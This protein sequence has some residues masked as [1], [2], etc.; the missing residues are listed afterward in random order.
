MRRGMNGEPTFCIVEVIR[1]PEWIQFQKVMN[2]PIVAIF[3]V[4]TVKI[5]SYPMDPGLAEIPARG[6]SWIALYP[7]PNGILAIAKCHGL[8]A[9]T[10]KIFR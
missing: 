9:R 1:L 2:F 8:Q 3:T 10:M 4:C 7:R 6:V 5:S